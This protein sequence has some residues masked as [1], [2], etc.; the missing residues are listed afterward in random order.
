MYVS[1]SRM[2]ETVI[3]IKSA[4]IPVFQLEFSPENS[5]ALKKRVGDVTQKLLASKCLDN[6]PFDMILK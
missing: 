3:N 4:R 5:A 2:H 6:L 1:D